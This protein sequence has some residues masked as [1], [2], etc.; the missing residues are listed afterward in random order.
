[1]SRRVVC[2]ALL[3]GCVLLSGC[4]VPRTANAAPA[5]AVAGIG[6]VQRLM[7]AFNAHDVEAMNRCV[8]EDVQWISL[9]AATLAVETEGRAA[10]AESMT[11]YFRALP[12]ERSEIEVLQVTDGFV[13]V[14][15]RAH[16]VQDGEPRSQAALAVYELRGDLV[17][18]V[19]YFAPER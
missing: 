2:L 6:P 8:T 5:A 16:W 11:G 10:L 17:A 4:A 9:Q 13:V 7:D 3:S 15:E 14:R 12:T 19:W 1:M 18:R